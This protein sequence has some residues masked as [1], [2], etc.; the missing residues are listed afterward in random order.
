MTPF[1]SRNRTWGFFGTVASNHGEDHARAAWPIASEELARAHPGRSP[2]L[3]RA[4][5]DSRY[6]R[7]LADQLAGPGGAPP[8]DLREA[9]RAGAS[10]E[11]VADAMR[12]VTIAQLTSSTRAAD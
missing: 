2:E 10:A 3:I 5:R 6:G 12:K 9:I 11:W 7:H 8:Q 4:F 1:E